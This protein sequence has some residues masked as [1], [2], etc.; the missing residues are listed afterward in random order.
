MGVV[1]LDAVFIS[2]ND[3]IEFLYDAF[4]RLQA[5]YGPTMDQHICHDKVEDEK[6]GKNC[7]NNFFVSYVFL[8]FPSISF[9]RILNMSSFYTALC[10]DDTKITLQLRS[11]P[12]FS[13]YL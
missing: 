7:Q 8:C 3:Y 11:W 1:L 6:N 13:A 9:H 10:I 5:C 2:L 4:F 12:S